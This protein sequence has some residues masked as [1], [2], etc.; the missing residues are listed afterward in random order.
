MYGRGARSRAR[1]KT[2]AFGATRHRAKTAQNR[3]FESHRA[4]HDNS[5]F[6]RSRETIM[7]R[8]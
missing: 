8:L 4:R 3:G 1:T 7:I 2:W 5:E 6:D